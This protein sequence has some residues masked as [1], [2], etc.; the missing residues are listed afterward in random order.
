MSPWSFGIGEIIKA[1]NIWI[2]IL[3]R[4]DNFLNTAL[5]LGLGG[6][7]LIKFCAMLYENLLPMEDIINYLTFNFFE[8][9]KPS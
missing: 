3:K 6:T 9:M 7:A 1:K 5:S 4:Q 8:K 2:N